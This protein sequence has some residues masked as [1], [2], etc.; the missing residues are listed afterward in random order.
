[1]I[2]ASFELAA[3][4]FYSTH[5]DSERLVERA[6][7][8]PP[9]YALLVGRARRF[10]SLATQLH[11]EVFGAL[12]KELTAGARAVVATCHGEIQTADA[13]MTDFHANALV[14]GARFALSV[15]NSPAGVI[16]V[17]TGNMRPTVTVTGAHAI[18]AGWLEA[19]LTALDEDVP[20]V[21]TIADEPVPPSL[22]GP[23]ERAGV[24]AGFVL[25]RG[26]GFELSLV[27]GDGDA[28]VDTVQ[29]LARLV[30]GAEAAA[31]ALGSV[32]PGRVLQL[33]ASAR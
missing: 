23:P 16:S 25:R 6:N 11:A 9:A 33:Q 30:A 12:P 13:L 27:D 18:A 8:T 7:P 17:A 10:T 3:A 20:V 14:S 24:A 32:Q 5:H 1:M 15:H 28:P 2:V 22:V 29:T 19:A 31:I 4:T 21:L 26:R